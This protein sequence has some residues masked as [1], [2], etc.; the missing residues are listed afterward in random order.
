M[1]ELRQAVFKN[2][3]WK[4]DIGYLPRAIQANLRFY[5]IPRYQHKLDVDK[6]LLMGTYRDQNQKDLAV[7]ACVTRSHHGF[8]NLVDIEFKNEAFSKIQLYGKLQGIPQKELDL[9]NKVEFVTPFD[10]INKPG[11]PNWR[12]QIR[13]LVLFY[14]LENDLLST[15]TLTEDQLKAFRAACASVAKEPIRSGQKPVRLR[16]PKGNKDSPTRGTQP[17]QKETAS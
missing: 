4:K 7:Y 3:Q 1:D 11:T 9:L 16:W 14:F 10:K 6:R 2:A 12:K 8:L 17:T 15:I 13:P 5:R